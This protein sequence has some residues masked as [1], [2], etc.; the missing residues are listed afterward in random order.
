ML[1]VLPLL[2]YSSLLLTIGN[3]QRGADWGRA[4]LR[5]AI[6]WGTYAAISAELLSLIH[7]IT[8]L[9][10]ALAWGL[11]LAVGSLVLFQQKKRLGVLLWPRLQWPRGWLDRILLAGIV[12]ILAVTGILGL[13]SPPQSNDS[14]GYHMARV[15]HW[16][17]NRSLGH[18]ATGIEMQNSMSP[19]GEILVLHSYVL[20]QGDRLA[21][22]VQWAAMVFSALAASILARQLGGSERSGWVAAAFV[23]SLP[24]GIAEASNTLMDY[25]AAFWVA[26]AVAETLGLFHPVEAG[27]WKANIGFLSLATGMALLTKGSSIPFLAPFGLGVVYFLLRRVRLAE[28]IRWGAIGASLILIPTVGYLSRNVATY[29][30][31]FGGEL[32]EITGNQM[33][34]LKGVLSISLRNAA[35]HAGTPWPEVNHWIFRGVAAVHSKLGVEV[36]DPRT[37]GWGYFAVGT[38]TTHEAG[39]GNP[40]HAYLSLVLFGVLVLRP[41]RMGRLPLMYGVA[42]AAGFVLFSA[43]FKWQIWGSRLHLPFF[44]V[45]GPLA[46]IVMDHSLP[47]QIPRLVGLA[48]IAAS[49]PWLLG[50]FS[51]PIIPTASG[52][53]VPSVLR[54]SRE[55]LYYVNVDWVAEG[56]RSVT[57]RISENGCSQVGLVLSGQAM[58]YL[59]W[60]ELGAPREDLRLEWF[61]A[62]TPSA[63]YEAATFSPCAVICEGCPPDWT[64]IRGLPLR[65]K[66]GDIW[67]FMRPQ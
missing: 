16:A 29:G 22:S 39:A 19:G 31:L 15:A 1:I 47:R 45:L 33:P 32:V 14:L 38:P 61:V 67:L 44:V 50:I 63:R 54:Q 49:W 4:G 60:A 34:T 13:I 21:N 56:Y 6:L 41:R 43:A 2:T 66:V 11:A 5:A 8:P 57:A 24:M 52:T 25:A 7:G 42:L 23:A 65:E 20:T 18:F 9:G 30:D 46:A 58:E 64:V 53:N 36:N 3:M 10:L 62:G 55:D 51:R 59:L 35:L 48:L 37:T 26:G 12:A 17:Q 28:G 40:A 27:G